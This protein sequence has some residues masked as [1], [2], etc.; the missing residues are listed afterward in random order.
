MVG[1]SCRSM[2][3]LWKTTIKKT[4]KKLTYLWASGITM[5]RR[6]ICVS[7]LSFSPSFSSCSAT[8][9]HIEALKPLAMWGQQFCPTRG[10]WRGAMCQG[11]DRRW[12]ALYSPSPSLRPGDGLPFQSKPP[13]PPAAPFCLGPVDTPPGVRAPSVIG[14]DR[15][16]RGSIFTLASTICRMP[17]NKI[18][19][20]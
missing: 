6:R 2:T 19:C 12:L 14:K 13:F 4:Q 8:L 11:E 5:S 17:F 20:G 1:L 10:K 3:L 18:S 9:S 16:W 15:K 7:P